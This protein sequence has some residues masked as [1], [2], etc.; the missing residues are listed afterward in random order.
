M[1]DRSGSTPLASP[2]FGRYPAY[3]DSG[4]EWLGEVPAHWELTT[5]KR[6]FHVVNGSTPKT[7]N[8]RFWNGQI[9][10]ITPED[11]GKHLGPTIFGSERTISTAGLKSCGASLVPAGSIV[12][13]T[14]APIGHMAIAG[15][16]LCTNQGCRCL[17][18]RV[19]ASERYAFYRLVAV[20]RRLEAL[21][22]G[23]TFKELSKANLEEVEIADPPVP[24]QRA[25]SDFLDRETAK[26]DALITKQE[27]LIDLLR[28]KRTSLISHAVTKGLDPDAP[29]S[30]SGVEWLGDVPDGWKVMPLKRIGR[31][32]GGTGFPVSAQGNREA[33][34]LFAKVSDMNRP[35]NHRQLFSAANTVTRQMARDLGAHVFPSGSIVFPKVG[36]AL[37]TNK[38]RVL[39]QDT[40]IDNNVM[41][42]IVM[43]ADADF[44]FWTLSC[45][46]LGRVSK[47]GPVP[48]IGEGE[49]RDLRAAFP[50]I[51]E[52]RAIVEYLDRETAKF[53]TLVAK[54]NEAIDRLKEYR[55]A[56]I[57][58][59]VTG[60]IDVRNP[61]D[62][63]APDAAYDAEA[64]T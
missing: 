21:G 36:A 52:Q 24:E 3:R 26:I 19:R 45:I 14:R 34:I 11:L 12:L 2:R 63:D 48:A 9:T 28:E 17:V 58:A 50:P 27:A 64:A 42:C 5:V 60:Q 57:S 1:N 16:D 22:T 10:W 13:S 55:A 61:P 8:S 7:T 23:S 18:F 30:D 32:S 46:D 47:L 44:V 54:A 49:V 62:P 53:D 37:L 20:R 59:A 35:G 40:C 38:R 56:L 43:G 51:R 4:I 6:I 33:E 25:I 41:G 39:V 15:V 31:F 29:M